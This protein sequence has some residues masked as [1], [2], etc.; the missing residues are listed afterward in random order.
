MPK[1]GSP[2]NKTLSAQQIASALRNM[3]Y[4]I[5]FVRNI[6]YG[7]CGITAQSWDKL[8]LKSEEVADSFLP[9]LNI[10]FQEILLVGSKVYSMYKLDE[11]ETQKLEKYIAS[12]NSTN[13]TFGESYPLAIDDDK[14]S[15]GSRNNEF[16]ASFTTEINDKKLQVVQYCCRAIYRKTSEVALSEL[17]DSAKEKFEDGSVE[18]IKVTS[19]LNTQLFNSL[20]YNKTDS[21]LLI[22]ADTSELSAATDTEAALVRLKTNLKQ[23]FKFKLPAPIN[24]FPKIEDMYIEPNGRV[25]KVEFITP[26]DSINSLSI[27]PGDRDVRND[28]Y[29]KAGEQEVDA[30]DKFKIE[31]AWDFIFGSHERQISPT[32]ALNGNKKL[33]HAA[34]TLDLFYVKECPTIKHLVTIVEDAF[35]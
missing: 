32:I 12:L 8:I 5:N 29:H 7:V 23:H 2:Q 19:K 4:S 21:Y 20:I 9:D 16:M 18:S 24:L 17:K 33:L 6:F 27:K 22:G 30:L 15:Q 25:T 26:S 14:L 3:G 35:F 34:D 11:A 31:K 1:D 28:S 10:I 13:T